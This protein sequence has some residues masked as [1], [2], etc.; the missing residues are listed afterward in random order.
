[1]N[2]ETPGFSLSR[3]LAC[4]RRGYLSRALGS[5]AALAVCPLA[6]DPQASAAAPSPPIARRG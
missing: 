6:G 1:M 4:T 5:L 2:D 3:L